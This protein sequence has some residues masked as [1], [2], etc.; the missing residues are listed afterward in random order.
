MSELVVGKITLPNGEITDV[1]DQGEAEAG[2]D[3]SKLMT[4]LRTAQLAAAAT[5]GKILQVVQSIESS[6]V[7]RTTSTSFI[8]TGLE[9]VITPQ[10]SNSTILVMTSQVIELRVSST[11]T[12]EAESRLMRDSTQLSLHNFTYR[13]RVSGSDEFYTITD[14]FIVS[15]EPNTTSSVTYK[16]QMRRE[17]RAILTSN[18]SNSESYIILIEI[19]K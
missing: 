3:N 2:T 14:V 12:A 4:P 15:D 8:D 18:N 1:A 10:K 11:S 9:A 16:T 19:G 7:S 13:F 6:E 17:S 5:F